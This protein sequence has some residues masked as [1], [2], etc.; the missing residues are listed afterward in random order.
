MRRGERESPERR[1]ERE[2][3]RPERTLSKV[4]IPDEFCADYI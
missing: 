2:R 3:E 4:W 1:R